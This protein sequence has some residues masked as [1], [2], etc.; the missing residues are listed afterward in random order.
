MAKKIQEIFDMNIKTFESLQGRVNTFKKENHIEN[1]P[2]KVK[3]TLVDQATTLCERYEI[4]LDSFNNRDKAH[5]TQM[6]QLLK[7][8]ASEVDILLDQI[9]QKIHEIDEMY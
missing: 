9:D 2:K 6:N 3:G 5:R 4:L 8:L 1:L 7:L